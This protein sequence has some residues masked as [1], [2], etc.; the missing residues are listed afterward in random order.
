MKS[1]VDYPILSFT[2]ILNGR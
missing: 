2:T 1:Y